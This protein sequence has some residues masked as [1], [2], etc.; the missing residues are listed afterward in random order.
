MLD[1]I[2]KVLGKIDSFVWGIPLIALILL[3]GLFLSVRL[4]CVQFR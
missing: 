4:K 1:T 2:N 3:S